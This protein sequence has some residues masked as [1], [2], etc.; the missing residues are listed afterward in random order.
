MA[1]ISGACAWRFCIEWICRTVSGTSSIRT[2]IVR[3]TIDHDQEPSRSW[4]WISAHDIRSSSGWRMLA[5]ITPDRPR[6]GSRDCSGAAASLPSPIPSRAR[7]RAA[8]RAHTASSSGGT[9]RCWPASAARTCTARRRRGRSRRTSRCRLLEHL[10]HPLRE[11]LVAARV[12]RLGEPGPRYEHVVVAGTYSVRELRPG[13]TELPLDP[14]ADDGVADGLRHGK[15]QPRLLR[16]VRLRAREPVEDEEA[17]RGRTTAAI[18]GVEVP[19]AGQAVAALHGVEDRPG[20]VRRRAACVPW[21]GG[22]SG[23]PDR[24]GSPCARGSRACACGGGRS[25]GR[26]ASKE[27]SPNRKVIALEG[28]VRKYRQEPRNPV[29]HRASGSGKTP[30]NHQRGLPSPTGFPQLW[31]EVWTQIKYLQI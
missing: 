30:A 17:G 13:F 12:G 7:G 23:S 27:M 6:R 3:A 1:F 25:A 20:G 31:I 2:M 16:P 28:G 14:V 18:D 15:T 4:R 5:T 11:P 26:C 24:R 10:G 29:F 19:R 21:R 22:A 9:C 8:R